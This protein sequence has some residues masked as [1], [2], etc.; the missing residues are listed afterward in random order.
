MAKT[1]RLFK[2]F[3]QLFLPVVTLIVVAL[4]AAS[5]WFVHETSQPN[6]TAYLVTPEKYG[7]LSTRGARITDESWANTDGTSA[8]GWLLRGAEGSPAVIL[9]HRYGANRSHVLDLGIKINEATNFTILMPD[10]RGHGAQPLVKNTS[11]GGCET[12]DATAAIQFLRGLKTDKEIT[13]VGE[14]IGFYGIEMGAFVALRAA[15]QEKNIKAL[16][17]DSVPSNSDQIL[18]SSIEKRFPFAVPITSSIASYGTYLY[19]YNNCYNHETACNLAKT[20]DDRQVLLLGGTDLPELQQATDK[21]SRCFAGGTNVETKLDFNPS[22]YNISNASI[23]QLNIYDQ[24]VIE[25]FN[26]T[27]K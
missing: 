26:K 6:A 4:G 14:N 19:F 22:G 13:L 3:F 25:F 10:Q 9:L 16:V 11:F 24:R 7:L 15:S 8:R 5:V 1:T 20:I 21:L 27:L 2:S 12:E 23:E 18:A 17:L